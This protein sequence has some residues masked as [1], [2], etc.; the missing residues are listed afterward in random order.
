[1]Q[2]YVGKAKDAFV[3][4]FK[5]TVAHFKQWGHEVRAFRSDAETV[6]KDGRMGQYLRD[7]GYVHELSVQ[8][9]LE[10]NSAVTQMVQANAVLYA[11]PTSIWDKAISLHERMGHVH[12]EA[13]CSAISGDSPAWTHRDLSPAR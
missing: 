5:S 10:A 13:M 9:Q 8:P 1:M 11:E 3:E 12:A 4:A 2:A 7:N 6:L